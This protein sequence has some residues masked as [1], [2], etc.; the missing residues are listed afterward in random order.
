M[1]IDKVIRRYGV[2]KS[3]RTI[4]E[5]KWDDI[6]HYTDPIMG[7]VQVEEDD[8][9]VKTQH[10]YDNIAYTNVVRLASVLN[11]MLTP[12]SERWFNLTTN[13]EAFNES[14]PGKE[15]LNEVED[16]LLRIFEKSNF[17]SEVQKNFKNLVNLGNSVMYI[18][19]D[20]DTDIIVRFSTRHIKEVYIAENKYG[21]V[22]TIY[23][24]YTYTASQC[25]E[26]W[27]DAVSDDVKK[28]YEE[29]PDKEVRVLHAVEP[30]LD[31]DADNKKS[32][33]MPYASLWLEEASRHLLDESGYDTFPYTVSRWDTVAGDAY[34]TS[35]MHTVLPNVISLQRMM[36]I[37]I[38]GAEL[39]IKPPLKG[40]PDLTDDQDEIIIEAGR[41]V[42]VDPN[43]QGDLRP[44]WEARQQQIGIEAIQVL[45]DQIVDILMGNQLSVIDRAKMTAEEVRARMSENARIIGPTSSRIQ[46]EFLSKLIERVYNVALSKFDAEGNPIIPEAPTDTDGELEVKLASPMAKLQRVSEIEAISQ[47][48]AFTGQLLEIKPDLLDNLDLDEALR[49]VADVNN[50]PPKVLKER[51]TVGNIRKLRAQQ[52][53]VMAQRQQRMEDE[54]HKAE[55]LNKLSQAERN[56]RGDVNE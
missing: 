51:D 22:D 19:D 9:Y 14:M 39:A 20:D 36:E 15:W 44:I 5:S 35:P 55:S 23:R 56:N 49:I 18:D 16:V 38:E 3:L 8:G 24:C 17:Y 29:S 2:L 37:F 47:T 7:Y 53:Q 54:Q 43:K 46:N 11:S 12:R 26:R 42:I 52:Q 48:V 34:G 13:D 21:E 41:V 45:R 30:R 31:Y 50:L 27:G 6:I 40:T 28:L 1:D 32:N 4:H 25:Y 10:I 33:N